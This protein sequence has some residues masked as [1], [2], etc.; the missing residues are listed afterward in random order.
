MIRSKPKGTTIFSLSLFLIID[1][2]IGIWAWTTMPPSPTVWII[3]PIACLV[4]ALIVFLKMLLGY[5]IITVNGNR[6]QVKRLINRN[7]SFSDEDIK[8]WKEIVIRTAG[9]LYKQLHVHAGKGNDAKISLQEHTEYQEVLKKLKTKH[10]LKEIKE[11]GYTA[12]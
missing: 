1:C 3:I 11:T 5:R 10:R 8:W 6:W 7:I 9:G 12:Q 4:V 2:A